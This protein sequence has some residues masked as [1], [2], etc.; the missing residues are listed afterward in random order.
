[1]KRLITDNPQDN[2]STALNL[3][4][5]KDRMTWVRGGGDAPDYPDV[6]LPDYMRQIIKKHDI[7]LGEPL[8][9]EEMDE[10]MTELLFDGTDTIE[11]ILATLYTTAWAFS[12]IRDHLAEYESAE[13]NGRLARLPCKVGDVLYEVDA[14][15]YGVIVCE[16]YRVTFANA[17]FAN[18]SDGE[19]VSG[20][21]VAVKVIKG[22]GTGSAYEFAAEDFGKIVFY[23]AEEAEAALTAKKRG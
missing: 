2:F 12:I 17:R 3:Y 16:V 20:V 11:G 1:M 15:E 14:P 22:H 9:D 19:I 8:S 4:Y 18:A 6:T 10:L 7:D 23:S 13:K 21:T 5:N